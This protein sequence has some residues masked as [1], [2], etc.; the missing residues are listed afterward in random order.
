VTHRLSFF[1]LFVCVALACY[2][3]Q[4]AT[5]PITMHRISGDGLDDHAVIARVIASFDVHG[6]AARAWY[7]DALGHHTGVDTAAFH[8][9]SQPMQTATFVSFTY[10]YTMGGEPRSR[11]Y[12]ARSGHNNPWINVPSL[13]GWRPYSTYLEPR[14]SDV[15]AEDRTIP[16]GTTVTHSPVADGRHPDARR[17]DAEL[18]VARRIEREIREGLISAGGELYGFSSQEPCESC[19]AALEALSD[20][21]GISV[22]VSYLAY[23]SEAYLSFDRMRRQYM[24][25]IHVAANGGQLNLL[26]QEAHASGIAPVAVA[27]IDTPDDGEVDDR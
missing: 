1:R 15:V 25:S 19:E 22:N 9:F 13:T 6:A 21:R 24:T 10:N 26:N 17:R 5:A 3:G 18:K 16:I 4:A 12:H 7:V 14:E 20:S 27:C 2:G 11:V 8:L 23:R